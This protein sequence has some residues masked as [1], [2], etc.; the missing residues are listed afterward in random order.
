[1]A[2]RYGDVRAPSVRNVGS[3]L[4]GPFTVGTARAT[5][6][7]ARATLG[8]ACA[9][10][11][12]ARAPARN[13]RAVVGSSRAVVGSSHAVVGLSHAVVGSSCAVTG[14]SNVRFRSSSVVRSTVY[15]EPR[16]SGV[17]G[18][19]DVRSV[20]SFGCPEC[21]VLLDVRSVRSWS[22]LV[23]SGLDISGQWRT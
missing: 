12:T 5:L 9:T 14:G 20:R 19:L 13:A 10:L 22:G 17:S 23:R 1:M 7:T 15:G 6:G 2:K 3:S 21:P 16:V 11:G 8:T 4:S 18:P